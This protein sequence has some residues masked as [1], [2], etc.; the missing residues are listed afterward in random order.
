MTGSRGRRSIARHAVARPGVA[1][2]FHCPGTISAG[3]AKRVARPAVPRPTM[4]NTASCSSPSTPDTRNVRY[5]M[6][7]ATTPVASVRHSP[8]TLSRGDTPGRMWLKRWIG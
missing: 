1:I 8:R 7:V 5:A 6:Q 2:G 3:S 4:V